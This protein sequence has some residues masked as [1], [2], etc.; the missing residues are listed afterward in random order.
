MRRGRR[1][2]ARATAKGDHNGSDDSKVVRLFPEVTPGDLV[3]IGAFGGTARPQRESE[4]GGQAGAWSED[5]AAQLLDA[6]EVAGSP[7]TTESAPRYQRFS[8]RIVFLAFAGAALAAGVLAVTFSARPHPQAE[9]KTVAQP[10]DAARM[11]ARAPR[12]SAETARRSRSAKRTA[13]ARHQTRTRVRPKPARRQAA[14]HRDQAKHVVPV[15]ERSTSSLPPPQTQHTTTAP[16]AQAPTESQ[17]AA[18]SGS[19]QSS[20][21][22]ASPSSTQQPAFGESGALGPGHSPAS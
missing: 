16:P 20:G 3:P 4:N 14:T 8:A 19:S 11:G 10:T 2:R 13:P 6:S 5:R 18:V 22:G 17:P 12:A 9:K 1:R 21:S 7:D 15:S